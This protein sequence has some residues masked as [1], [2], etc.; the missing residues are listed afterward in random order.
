MPEAS[1]TTARRYL[2]HLLPELPEL[3]CLGVLAY[4]RVPLDAA[5]RLPHRV[6]D[7]GARRP[8]ALLV[9]EPPGGTPLVV[10]SPPVGA[11]GTAMVVEE[12]A[13]L[14]LTHLLAV[15][16]AGHPTLGGPCAL[17]LGDAV[18]ATAGLVYEGTSPHY[19]PHTTEVPADPGLVATLRRVLDGH[20]WP[21]ATGPV[22]TTD[23]LYRETPSFVREVQGRGALAVD[24][25]VSALLTVARHRGIPATALL[26]VSDLLDPDRGWTPGLRDPRLDLAEARLL[27][28]LLDLA[29]ELSC[30]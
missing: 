11:P 12:L 5:R 28:V 18:V 23:A 24:M 13:A 30:A 3:P 2:E 16:P 26:L 8:S 1:L 4:A 29:R 21:H 15:G 20:A 25:E 6:I 10:M 27:P 22:A 9:V 14:G 19:D 7:L 17:S